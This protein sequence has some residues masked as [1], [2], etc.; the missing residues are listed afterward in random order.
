MD[1]NQNEQKH[2]KL[3]S[4]NRTIH[5]TQAN[6]IM[7]L[8][9]HFLVV[10]T[11]C[12][13]LAACQDLVQ[14]RSAASDVN[15]G[16]ILKPILNFL[17]CKKGNDGVQLLCRLAANKIHGPLVAASIRADPS[18]LLFT[19][20]DPTK[21]K[22]STG[23]SCA[24]TADITSVDVSVKLLSAVT[25]NFSAKP[26]NLSDP[27]VFAAELPVELSA[28]AT[29]KQRFGATIPWI[30]CQNYASDTSHATGS[31]TT[32]A[33]VAILFTVAPSLTTDA[34]GNFVLTIKPIT[35][36]ASQLSSMK[37]NFKVSG[38]SFWSGFLTAILGSLTSIQNS[39]VSLLKGDVIGFV[40]NNIKALLDQVAGVILMLPDSLIGSLVEA[41][42]QR[43]V[44]DQVKGVVKGY[45][46][47][48]ENTLRSKIA[49]VLHLD[50][51][52]ARRFVVKKNFVDL[53]RQFGDGADI[54]LSASPSRRTVG[55]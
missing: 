5:L 35:K 2:F 46:G 20:N 33:K 23:H 24:I 13:S 37:V 45:T 48:M 8:C 25:L 38:I 31:T 19:Y 11:L 27:I 16:E 47:V 28:R 15:L 32:V 18:S 39:I 4:P 54:W 3:S 10:A 50:A 17:D 49:Q 52:G 7:N 22:I 40:W 29:I 41:L 36:A 51:K 9:L 42:A 30:G 43:Y 26:F 21:R 44:Q 53:V 1:N 12:A 55:W 34:G 14:A 6:I